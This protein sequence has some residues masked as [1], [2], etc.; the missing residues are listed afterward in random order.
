MMPGLVALGEQGYGCCCTVQ[1]ATHPGEGVSIP[2]GWGC[3]G[4]HKRRIALSLLVCAFT[5]ADKTIILAETMSKSIRAGY[6]VAGPRVT[7]PGVVWKGKAELQ[8]VKYAISQGR[9]K[10]LLYASRTPRHTPPTVVQT[11]ANALRQAGINVI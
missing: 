9:S 1:Y 7:L 10:A 6:R 4:N 5:G 8:A 11:T 3:D 2:Y